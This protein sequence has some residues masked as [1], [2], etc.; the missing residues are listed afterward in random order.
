M[1]HA[2]KVYSLFLPFLGE[3]AK[4]SQL[5]GPEPIRHGAFALGYQAL[6]IGDKNGEFSEDAVAKDLDLG[7]IDVA[8]VRVGFRARHIKDGGIGWREGATFLKGIG[9]V[10]RGDR[11]DRLIDIADI[12]VAFVGLILDIGEATNDFEIPGAKDDVAIVLQGGVA[13][14]QFPPPANM[15]DARTGHF[16]TSFLAHYGQ[17]CKGK[18]Q[19]YIKDKWR[20]LFGAKSPFPY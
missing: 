9:G 7:L 17:N 14:L 2:G 1:S 8:F 11:D 6:V 4:K 13:V 5:K 15:D 16:D 19:N 10:D 20:P 3:C 18:N 12:D